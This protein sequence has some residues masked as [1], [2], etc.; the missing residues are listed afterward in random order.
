MFSIKNVLQNELLFD[1]GYCWCDSQNGLAWVKYTMK[2]LRGTIEK[3]SLEIRIETVVENLYYCKTYK[4][5]KDI[6]TCNEILDIA[7]NKLW[8]E[9]TIFITE[10]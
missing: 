4:I 2:V 10:S 3:R 5:L 6:T 9:G 8:W 7:K 1:K